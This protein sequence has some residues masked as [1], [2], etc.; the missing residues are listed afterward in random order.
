[1]EVHVEDI[2][3]DENDGG[4]GNILHIEKP[5]KKQEN[6]KDVDNAK[7]SKGENDIGDKSRKEKVIEV[8]DR[9]KSLTKEV[10]NMIQG[11]EE[12]GIAEHECQKKVD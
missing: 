11:G 4:G 6:I 9:L 10:E 5:V 2:S 8:D 7:D 3:N 1:M 12:E